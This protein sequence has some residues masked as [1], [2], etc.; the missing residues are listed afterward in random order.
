MRSNRRRT[1]IGDLDFGQKPR[2]PLL[3]ARPANHRRLSHRLRDVLYSLVL[4]QSRF[5]FCFGSDNSIIPFPSVAR[6]LT[7]ASGIILLQR[8]LY[9]EG[10]KSGE[11]KKKNNSNGWSILYHHWDWD[12]TSQYFLSPLLFTGQVVQNSEDRSPTN[13]T[14]PRRQS[15]LADDPWRRIH[16]ISRN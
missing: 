16:L 5:F 10:K 11:G 7:R 9:W 8:L 4:V 6:F 1:Y 15:R 3:F 12:L 2:L 14:S 13:W